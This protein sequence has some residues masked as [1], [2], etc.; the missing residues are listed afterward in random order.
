MSL[1]K[2]VFFFY[3]ILLPF[4]A[5]HPLGLNGYGAIAKTPSFFFLA[6]GLL[7]AVCNQKGRIV[8]D[9]KRYLRKLTLLISSVSLISIIMAFFL[10]YGV[11]P[12]A[13]FHTT[14]VIWSPI[15]YNFMVI[16][17]IYYVFYM[18]EKVDK[19]FIDKVLKTIYVYTVVLGYIQLAAIFGNGACRALLYGLESLNLTYSPEL[20]LTHMKVVLMFSEPSYAEMLL[21]GLLMPF[22]CGNIIVKSH[23]TLDVLKI[24]FLMPLVFFNGSSSVLV[25]TVICIAVTLILSCLRGDISGKALLSIFSVFVILVLICITNNPIKEIIVNQIL[26]KPFDN[27]NLSTIQR[28]SIIRNCIMIFL[29]YP[30]L[31]VGNGVQ[32]FFYEF[33]LRPEDYK[34]Y[35]VIN[36]LKYENGVPGAGSWAGGWLS[37][38]GIVGAIFL[39]VFIVSTFRA[40]KQYRG[41]QYYYA[42][43]IG[44]ICFLVCGWFT[45]STTGGYL[46]LFIL[47]IP[48]FSAK[49]FEMKDAYSYYN[50]KKGL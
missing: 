9:D 36:T 33:H 12:I 43:I 4:E 16:A 35:E 22:I 19:D 44:G 14:D 5:F 20:C 26:I 42:Y 25:G 29:K 30:I 39:I 28:G 27:D 21:C 50:I 48:T 32:G 17:I 38:Y 8:L 2:I 46:S 3:L 24:L 15:F 31:G 6:I 7:L 49:Y 18:S 10:Y 37:G 1:E 41:S 13:G 11:E 47:S 23:K 34:S 45:A 40:I